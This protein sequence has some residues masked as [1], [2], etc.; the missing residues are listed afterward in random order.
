MKTTF[1]SGLLILPV[2]A[3]CLTVAS[4]SSAQTLEV[5]PGSSLYDNDETE[6]TASFAQWMVKRKLTPAELTWITGMAEA[7]PTGVAIQLAADAKSKSS[8]ST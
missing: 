5:E 2:A 7:T 1:R 6:F 8:A 3:L 4:A